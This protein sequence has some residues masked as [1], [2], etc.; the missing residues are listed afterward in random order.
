MT[1]PY[2]K[3]K[4]EVVDQDGN[5]LWKR[6]PNGTEVAI[7]KEGNETII[8]VGTDGATFQQVGAVLPK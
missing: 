8:K 4:D 5:T 3:N 2:F 1:G 6:Y 7:D